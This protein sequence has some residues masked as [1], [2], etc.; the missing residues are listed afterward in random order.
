MNR[1]ATSRFD[2]IQ[3]ALANSPSSSI[4]VPSFWSL[5]TLRSLSVYRPPVFEFFASR[6]CASTL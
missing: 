2:E 1:I 6:T 4:P 3:S 5:K